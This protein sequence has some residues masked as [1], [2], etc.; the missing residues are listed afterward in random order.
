MVTVIATITMIET[1]ITVKSF[2][3]FTV[4]IGER[5]NFTLAR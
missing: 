2:K 5:F 4:E 1:T 3:S